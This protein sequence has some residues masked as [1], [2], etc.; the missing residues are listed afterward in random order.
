[1]AVVNGDTEEVTLR[2]SDDLPVSEPV[3]DRIRTPSEENEE[4][5]KRESLSPV[6]DVQ[7]RV[8]SFLDRTILKRGTGTPVGP[9]AFRPAD[10]AN[11][12]EEVREMLEQ[13]REEVRERIREHAQEVEQIREE[14]RERVQEKRAEIEEKLQEIR[15][16]R[17]R[18]AAERVHEN[19]FQVRERVL[20]NFNDTL[21]RLNTVLGNVTTRADK[22][23]NQGANVDAVR[24][25]IQ[26]ATNQIEQARE[27]VKET[28][29]KEYEVTI[30]GE[31][32]LRENFTTFRN[33]LR[34]DLSDVRNI[35][36]SA[37]EAT[38]SAADT[39]TQV[40]E[41]LN[42]ETESE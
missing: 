11:V 13:K 42:L 25:A 21:D 24:T 3:R 20:E 41:D 22:A 15:N 30:T 4:P 10:E 7:N 6:R 33:Q 18:E 23:E 8:K 12:P 19:L 40:I 14:V 38:R 29:R 16:E 37:H 32:E 39:L 28:F 35:V 5:R 26:N 2:E 27:R 9:G 17:R 1:M 31:E 34:N 36:R